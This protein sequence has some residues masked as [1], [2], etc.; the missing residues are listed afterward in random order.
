L[1]IF[2]VD[3]AKPTKTIR[4]GKLGSIYI[5]FLSESLPEGTAMIGNEILRNKQLTRKN[6]GTI[7]QDRDVTPQKKCTVDKIHGT[8]S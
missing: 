3:M 7:K 8:L 2:S 4:N 1:G 6:E 5:E